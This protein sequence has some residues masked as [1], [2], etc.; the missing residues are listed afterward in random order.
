MSWYPQ[1]GE[2]EGIV[3]QV[4]GWGSM[5]SCIFLFTAPLTTMR[6]MFEH[7][8]VLQFSDTPYVVSMA[9]CVL[10]IIYTLYTPGRIQP[11][12]TNG[13]G[14]LMQTIYIVFFLVYHTK[15]DRARLTLK[16]SVLLAGGVILVSVAQ[17]IC[18]TVEDRE[19]IVGVVADIFNVGMYGAPLSVMGTVM[20][21]KSVECMP[22]GLTLGTVFASIMW[23][24][25]AKWV[26]DGF[27]GLPNDL[28]LLLGVAQVLLYLKYR[29]PV[30]DVDAKTG[31]VN[32]TAKIVDAADRA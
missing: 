12:A 25:Y 4:L 8:S 14:A 26:G 17:F 1:I 32:S 16:L 24:T 15:T 20:K 10:W 5:A 3:Y 7:K 22:L 27:M 18:H 13:F 31:L 30:K 2:S 28:G 11:L 9:N 21:T 19:N 6:T 29:T 23:G